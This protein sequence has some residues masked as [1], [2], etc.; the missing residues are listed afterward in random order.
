MKIDPNI[1]KVAGKYGLAGG[2]MI[3]LAFLVFFYIDMQPWRNMVSFILDVVIIAFFLVL[4]IRE[5]KVLYRGGELR[6][7]HGMSIGFLC[8]LTIAGVYAVFYGLFINF[9]E[10]DFLQNYIVLAIED[11]EGRKELLT[12]NIEGDPEEF[13]NQQLEGIRSITKSKLVL[14]AFFKRTLIGFFLTP[15]ISV[16]FRTPQSP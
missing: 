2:T 6:F 14:D 11:Y 4:A 9:I 15:M 1:R 5:Y 7:Y 8:F 3:V 10:P 16:I 12:E 13:F